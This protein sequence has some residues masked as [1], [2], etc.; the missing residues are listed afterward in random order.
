MT[1]WGPQGTRKGDQGPKDKS[2]QL[3]SHSHAIYFSLVGF[4]SSSELLQLSE[5][6]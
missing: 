5:E 2:K 3:P 4:Y 6:L 1:T